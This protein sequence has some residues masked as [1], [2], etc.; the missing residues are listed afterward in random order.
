MPKGRQSV[1]R[2]SS[3]GTRRVILDRPTL[4]K[5]SQDDATGG[6]RGEVLESM[7][8]QNGSSRIDCAIVELQNLR[9]RIEHGSDKLV[10]CAAEF[11]AKQKKNKRQCEDGKNCTQA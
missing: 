10:D 11:R 8:A 6:G 2:I 1:Q 9:K 3:A 4:L 7:P 5:I